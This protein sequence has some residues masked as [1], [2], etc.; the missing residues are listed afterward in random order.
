MAS[1]NAAVSNIGTNNFEVASGLRPI[2]SIAFAPIMPIASPGP[3]DPSPMAIAF[4][5]IDKVFASILFVL[6]IRTISLHSWND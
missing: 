1:A 2:A 4:A 3:S 5:N 6:N